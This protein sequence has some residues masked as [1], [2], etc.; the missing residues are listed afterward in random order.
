VPNSLDRKIE[1]IRR[2]VVVCLTRLLAAVEIDIQKASSRA[3]VRRAV[4]EVQIRAE[5]L[6]KNTLSQMQGSSGLRYRWLAEDLLEIDKNLSD[7]DTERVIITRKQGRSS[8][9][10]FEAY[11][12]RAL[13]QIEN[14]TSGVL[15]CTNELFDE[16]GSDRPSTSSLHFVH[17]ISGKAKI[18]RRRLKVLRQPVLGWV[19]SYKFAGVL[20]LCGLIAIP[21]GYAYRASTVTGKPAGEA[22]KTQL[23]ADK[24]AIN[25]E[26][27]QP[28]KS[29]VEKTIAVAE[30][31][32]KAITL[33]PNLLVGL[34]LLLSLIQ[35]L[36]ITQR[37]RQGGVDGFR[38][39]LLNA[40]EG[41]K[42]LVGKG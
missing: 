6:L 28:D 7:I 17:E 12:D 38:K 4:G 31:I 2:D 33:V 9:D 10:I 1:R 25:R 30:H 14:T 36:F 19:Y 16:T 29:G 5:D 39:D 40:S 42:K 24:T 15:Q 13:R 37:W 18:M 20:L 11:V 21:I 34:A 22:V 3:D 35:Y 41:V 23:A 26:L 8:N 32:M 27:R